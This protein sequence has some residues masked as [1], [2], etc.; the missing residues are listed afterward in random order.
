MT[1]CYKIH[2]IVGMNSRAS[3]PNGCP[4]WASWWAVAHPYHV[5]VRAHQTAG[6]SVDVNLAV[7]YYLKVV[8]STCTVT[9]HHTIRQ[10]NTCGKIYQAH[11][12]KIV[13]FVGL[14]QTKKLMF[15]NGNR[16]EYFFL[17]HVDY[18]YEVKSYHT[19]KFHVHWRK[20]E[21]KPQNPKKLGTGCSFEVSLRA[22]CDSIAKLEFLEYFQW[23]LYVGFNVYARIH[24]SASSKTWMISAIFQ[25]K[26]W[27]SAR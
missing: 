17:W 27:K 10:A 3:L 12:Y 4:K 14:A 16:K 13:D 8:C 6:L 15:K 24:S 5:V 20:N 2:P 7:L 22:K 23:R 18:F 19:L 25:A 21:Q 1:M 26:R 9:R 11:H